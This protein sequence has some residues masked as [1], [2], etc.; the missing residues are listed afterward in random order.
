MTEPTKT[1]TERS[2]GK[3]DPSLRLWLL[4]ALALAGL[5]LSVAL[6]KHYFDVRSGA[7][8]FKS[9]CNIGEKMNCDAI[10]ASSYAELVTGFPLSSFAAG[11]FLALFIVT[12]A[13]RNAFWRRDALRAAFGLTGFSAAMSVIYF[14]IMAAA[15]KTFC[16][17]CLFVDGISIFSFVLVLSLKPEGFSKHKAD[18]G[19]WKVLA[20]AAA[21]SLLVSV[22]GL[23]TLD[24]ASVDGG[25]VNE[26]VD[27]VMTSAAVAVNAGDDYPSIGAKDAPVTI[28]EFS[29]FQCPFCRIAAFTLNSVLNRYPGKVRVVFRNY[30]LDQ[31]CNRLVQHSM[32]QYS[33]QAA[34]AAVCAQRQ[35]KFEAVYQEFFQNQEKVE[36]GKID[37]LAREAGADSAQLSGCVAAPESTSTVARDIEEGDRLGIQSTPT[38]Y[39]NGRKVMG[40]YPLAAWVK[41]IDQLLRQQGKS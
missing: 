17:L 26:L 11:W 14:A 40:A 34:R 25:T 12:I 32:H 20:G 38:I 8:G 9:F 1:S 35:G 31:A 37:D 5:G 21:A 19:K 22:L 28:V 4:A 10:A 30:P 27:S 29:D 23:K 16:L 18:R 6:T 39:V 15:L 7:A 13:A 24:A 36:A 3:S 33:C 2:S 41:I